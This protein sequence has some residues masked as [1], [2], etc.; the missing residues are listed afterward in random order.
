MV[1]KFLKLPDSKNSN[2]QQQQPFYSPLIQDDPCELVPETLTPAII[3]IHLCTSNQ[4]CPI[5]AN[6]HIFF[7]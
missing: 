1:N 4:T 3:I 5:A 7:I 2:N 6:Q